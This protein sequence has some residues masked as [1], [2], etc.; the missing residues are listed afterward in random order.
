V[1][2]CR[3]CGHQNDDAAEFCAACR[4]YLKW[5]H[6]PAAAKPEPVPELVGSGVAAVQP[7]PAIDAPPVSPPPSTTRP[8]REDAVHCRECHTDNEPDRELCRSCGAVLLRDLP[9]REPWWRRLLR[10]RPGPATAAGER[11]SKERTRRKHRGRKV[12]RGGIVL[13]LVG[14]VAMLAGPWRAW[15]LRG[16]HNVSD[17][18]TTTYEPVKGV[19]AKATSSARGHPP[20]LAIDGVKNTAWAEG[21]R[22]LGANQSLTI[23]FDRKVDI[24]RVGITP[25]ASS[26]E[27]QFRAQPRPREIR[28]LFHGGERTVTLKDDAEFQ[29]FDVSAKGVDQVT[30][31]ILSIYSGQSGKDTSIAEVEFFRKR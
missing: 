23:R 5:E 20:T 17:R 8:V 19:S 13:V 9:K 6:E 30:L 10:R 14:A 15:V 18:V 28:L 24:S 26:K 31:E 16:Y 7:G 2:V 4:N 27:K 12:L 1:I 3:S 21:V 11:P 29:S 25:G 22:G